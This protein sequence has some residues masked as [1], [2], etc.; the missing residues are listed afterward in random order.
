MGSMCGRFKLDPHTAFPNFPK[1]TPKFDK[2]KNTYW[3]QISEIHFPNTHVLNTDVPNT[4]LPNP[5]LPN[6]VPKY[7]FH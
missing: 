4:D 6:T 7:G 3:S 1:K 5:D 2:C